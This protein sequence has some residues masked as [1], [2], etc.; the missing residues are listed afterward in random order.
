MTYRFTAPTWYGAKIV[1]KNS[2]SIGRAQGGTGANY[3]ATTTFIRHATTQH[4]SL[5]NGKAVAI[6]LVCYNT[7]DKRGRVSSSDLGA[8]KNESPY[9]T[10]GSR[11]DNIQLNLTISQTDTSKINEVY[12]S[13]ISTSFTEGALSLGL[14]GSY[15]ASMIKMDSDSVG[16]MDSETNKYTGGSTNAWDT[17]T[18]VNWSYQEWLLTDQQRHTMP[19]LSKYSLYSG[20]VATAQMIQKVRP[21]NRR[22]QFGSGYWLVILHDSPDPDNTADLNIHLDTAFK[23]IPSTDA[24]S[25]A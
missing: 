15:F 1:G 19:R 24:I 20:R 7:S 17:P 3:S 21:K 6:P 4:F 22:Q 14:M 13:T 5:A 12:V 9:A 25:V 23:E 16:T 10:I 2:A 18:P 8:S 11:V